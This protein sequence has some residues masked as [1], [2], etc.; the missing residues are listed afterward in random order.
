[1]MRKGF[2]LIEVMISVLIISLVIVALLEM[3]GN[4]SHTLLNLKKQIYVN[5]FNSFF[6]SNK[7]YVVESKSTTLDK[8]LSEFSISTDLRI[9]LKKVKI[10]FKYQ[11]LDTIDINYGMVIKVDKIIFNI[12]KSS[13]SIIRLKL[14]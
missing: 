7:N 8:L 4:S 10:D 11:E 12:D 13:T 3:H 2:T 9:A 5:T 14:R 6:I 1:M